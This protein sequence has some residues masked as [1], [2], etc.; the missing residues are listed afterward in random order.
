MKTSV[1]FSW[2][3]LTVAIAALSVAIVRCEPIQADWAS[4]LVGTLG[5]IVTALI[6]WQIYKSIEI[7]S[8]LHRVKSAE[9]SAKDVEL[10]LHATS[11]QICGSQYKDKSPHHELWHYML[12]LE[13]LNK[14]TNAQYENLLREIRRLAVGSSF[15]ILDKSR[16]ISALYNTHRE[17]AHQLMD[18]FS[19]WPD[20]G[21]PDRPDFIPRWKR[22]S[23]QQR[24]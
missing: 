10:M 12:A 5:G 22:S 19:E 3:I 13:Y 2:L 20:E 1:W 9:Q 24:K 18:I 11:E 15:S 23:A 8:I 17:D 21:S 16:L 14:A 6:G 4:I 7:N